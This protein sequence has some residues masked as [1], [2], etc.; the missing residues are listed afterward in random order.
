MHVFVTGATGFVGSAVVRE[1]LDAGHR[2]SALA[3]SDASAASLAAAGAQAVRGSL[4]DLASLTRGA[5]AADAVIHAAFN[6]DF[7]NFVANCETD[8]RAIGAIAAVLAG[9]DRTLVVTSGTALAPAGRVATEAD[10]A[11]TSLPRIATEEAA[12]S[13]AADGVHVC[14][15]RL[16]P[17]V[18][19]D[20]DHGFVPRLIEIA[21]EKGVSA[22]LGDGANLWPAVHRLD[23]ARLYRLVVE[24]H[25]PSPRYHGVAEQGIPFREIADAIGRRLGVPVVGIAREEAE[26]HFDW[27]AHFAAFDNPASSA[28]TR[29]ELGWTPRERG[30]IEDIERGTYFA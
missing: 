17:S 20:G 24:Q 12:A 8:R 6:H 15:L 29:A 21:R 7:T 1:L 14:V 28:A 23:A 18:H 11:A 30:L 9:S 22:Y 5:A 26:R 3:R 10:A 16:P 19:G 2:V 4:E 13:A 25:A 27:F